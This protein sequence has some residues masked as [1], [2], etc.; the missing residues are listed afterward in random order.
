MKRFDIPKTK[1]IRKS[2]RSFTPAEKAVFYFFVGLFMFS[3]V[4]LLFKVN[5]IFLMEIPLRGGSLTEGVI[6]NPRFINPVL[7]NSEADKNLV[8]LVY[9]GL[10]KVTPNGEVVNDI[11]S[12][13]VISEDGLNYTAHIRK[14]ATF[15]D[16]ARITASDVAFTIETITDPVIKSP[17]FLDWSGIEVEIIDDQ[18]ISFQLKKPYVPFIKNLSI[19]ILPLHIWKNV[20]DDEFTFSQFNILPIG[21]G[22]YKI[23]S[24]ERNSGGIPDY[25]NLKL[26]TSNI[27]G[28]P[29]VENLIFKFYPNEGD[30][31]EAFST[32]EIESMGGISPNEARVLKNSGSRILSSPLPRIFGVFFNGTESKAL[33]DKNIRKALDLATPKEEII[34]KVLFGYGTVIDGPLPPGL[35]PW[36]GEN[37]N[38]KSYEE[39]LAEARLILESNG[40]TKNPE[41]GILEKKSTADTIDLSFSISTGDNPE[42]KNVAEI[43]RKAWE[44][45]GARVEI[46]VFET[47]DL[48]QNVIRPR[49]FDAL[50]FGEVVGRDADVYP[51]WHSSQRMD[52][53][54]NIALYANSRVD[55]LL[56]ETRSAT[57][58][59]ER[60]EAYRSL[61]EEIKLDVPAVFLYAPNYLYVLPNK[62]QAISLGN[63]STTEDRY[64]GIKDWYIETNNVWEVFINK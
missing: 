54:L 56:E 61:D 59:T 17:Q 13:I 10:V 12:E 47:G 63:L 45:L 19:G 6:G 36:V 34:E 53:G 24:V 15:H 26:F 11:A 33:L 30:L 21:S 57:D 40:W 27:A 1:A 58:R 39:N 32:R 49:R 62:L 8:A 9:S 42:L 46:E 7:A 51:F 18:T 16:G 50:L 44:E 52:P 22:L 38:L 35:Y 31:F 41:S 14:D 60:E 48:N 37:I 20:T 2:M 55:K 64:L 43:V 28:G 25:Y 3:G 23:D 29:Y 4:A 5:D